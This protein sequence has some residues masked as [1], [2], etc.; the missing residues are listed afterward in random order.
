MDQPT[1]K[2][3]LLPSKLQIPLGLQARSKG[4]YICNQ[5][6]TNQSW[7]YK[8]QNNWCWIWLRNE[9]EIWSMYNSR[10]T[11]EI[12]EELLQKLAPCK[13]TILASDFNLHH[14]LWD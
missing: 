12:M 1:H 3:N 4:S 11:N 13:P 10:E 9:L 7:D 2:I 6:N 5:T 8:T 14:P